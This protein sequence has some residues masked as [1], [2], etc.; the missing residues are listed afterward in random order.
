MVDYQK[1]YEAFIEYAATGKQPEWDELWILCQR[2]ME[3]L[4]KTNFKNKPFCEGVP[5]VI[6]D[7]VSEVMAKMQKADRLDVESISKIF[8]IAYRNKSRD[9]FR[10]L[11]K[12]RR[13]DKAIR[14]VTEIY[15]PK[16]ADFSKTNQE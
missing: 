5:E 7:A 15:L 8:W 12:D 1:V 3:A 16:C 13:V 9:L 4:V 11:Q 2:R 10:E 14:M 6:T